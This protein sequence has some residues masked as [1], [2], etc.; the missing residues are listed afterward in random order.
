MIF[1]RRNETDP[2]FNI[3]AEEFVLKNIADDVLMLWQSSESVVIGK[4]QN[5]MLE[6]NLRFTLNESIPVLRR[7]SGGG[8]VYHDRGNL[9]YSLITTG[10][11]QSKLINFKKFTY[12]LIVFMKLQ[13][14]VATFEGKNNLTVKG[15]KFSGNSAHVFKTRI[16]HHGTLLFDTNLE[17]L[18]KAISLSDAKINDKS[19]RSIRAKVGNIAGFLQRKMSLNEFRHSL[20]V[21]LLHYYNIKTIREF[22]DKEKRQIATLAKT[23]YNSKEWIFGYSPNYRFKKEADTAYGKMCAD[24]NVSKGIIS[25]LCLEI[26]GKRLTQ[27]ERRLI[28][29]MHEPQSLTKHLNSNAFTKVLLEVLY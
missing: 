11:D 2:F 8:T 16:L 25:E 20:E 22:S 26:E 10:K 29:C 7:I 14:L 6:V 18:E 19:I 15:K 13:G 9:N 27:V 5:I 17:R 1:I 28:G 23:K 24:I 21:F 12:P 4:H 3:A